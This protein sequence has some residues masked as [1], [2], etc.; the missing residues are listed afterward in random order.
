[1]VRNA[2]SDPP[3]DGGYPADTDLHQMTDDGGLH[4][5]DPARWADPAWRDAIAGQ[6]PGRVTLAVPWD[7]A[8]AARDRLAHEGHPAILGLNA[9]SRTAG[10]ELWPGV[11]PAAAAAALDGMLTAGTSGG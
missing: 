10:L 8:D 9:R 7:R 4:T 3:T 6:R 5:P 2:T 11:D 1:M